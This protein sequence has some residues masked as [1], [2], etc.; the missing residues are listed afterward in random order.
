MSSVVRKF[1]VTKEGLTR[2]IK[3]ESPAYNNLTNNVLFP[4]SYSNQVLDITYEGNNFKERMV[5]IPP[6]PGRDQSPG[7]E[8]E[9]IVRITSG[10]LLAT[11]LGNNFK[12]YIRAWRAGTIDAGSPIEVYIA[13]QLLRVQEAAYENISSD[14]GDSWKISII[15][16]SSDY[17]VAGNAANRYNTTYIFKTPLTFTIV[18]GGVKNYITFRSALDQE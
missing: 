7:S 2:F 17:Y 10:P 11:S 4:F 8:T 6:P 1:G 16:P 14:S 15:A 12:N 9:T 13:P 5:D 3:P 18:E